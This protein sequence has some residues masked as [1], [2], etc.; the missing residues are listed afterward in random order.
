M[1]LA[2]SNHRRS[3]VRSS[4]CRILLLLVADEKEYA[5]SYGNKCSDTTDDAAC[6][7]TDRDGLLGI[8]FWG[9]CLRG[10]SLRA[11]SWCARRW[12]ARPG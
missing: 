5:N 7:S 9:G 1:P 2:M 6:N 4:S 12:R 10:R 8:G 3:V 11:R